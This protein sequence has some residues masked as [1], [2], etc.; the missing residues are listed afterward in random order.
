MVSRTRKLSFGRKHGL[1]MSAIIC[2][3]VFVMPFKP[4]VMNQTHQIPSCLAIHSINL[5]S[6][7]FQCYL[8][9]LVAACGRLCLVVRCGYLWSFVMACGCLWVFVAV[10]G[11]LWMAVFVCCCSLRSV[12]SSVLGGC[13]Y[14]LL[15]VRDGLWSLAHVR[16]C[17]WLPWHQ[18]NQTPSPKKARVVKKCT[19]E[20]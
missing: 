19:P 2:R 20:K 4:G 18:P 17:L 13:L 14:L 1:I 7:D 16:S 11:C 15:V 10:C 6:L 8:K 12:F 3:L 5:P 9:L